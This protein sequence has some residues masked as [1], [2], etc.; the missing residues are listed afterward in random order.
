MHSDD[1]CFVDRDQAPLHRLGSRF[2]ARNH[3]R[4]LP[5][6]ELLR[7][8][9]K[10]RRFFGGQDCYDFIDLSATLELSERANDYWNPIEFEELLGPVA[11]QPSSLPGGHNY[12]DVHSVMIR[13][14]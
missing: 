14:R 1:V 7:Q 5:Q 3:A 10:S 2:P 11:A 4:K 8:R 9:L 12:R 13:Y 6:S